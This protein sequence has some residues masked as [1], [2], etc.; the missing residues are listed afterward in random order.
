M[1]TNFLK[2]FILLALSAPLFFGCNSNEPTPDSETSLVGEWNVTSVDYSGTTV[3]E[4]LNQTYSVDYTGVGSNIDASY[5]FNENKSFTGSGTY[6]ATLTITS[7]GSAPY[8]ET[9]EDLGF[10]VAGTWKIDGD[11]ITLTS[12][13]ESSSATIVKLTETEMELKVSEQQIQSIE[14]TTITITVEL[15]MKLSKN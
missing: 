2:G 8:K 4:Y 6:D 11:Q 15:L 7:E 3:T 5:T 1:K 12:N 9:V 13:N 14:G 10:V